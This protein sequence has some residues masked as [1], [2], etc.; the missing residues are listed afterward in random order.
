MVGNIFDSGAVKLLSYRSAV[1]RW[2]SGE[3]VVPI[4]LEVQPTERCNH[5]CPDCQARYALANAEVRRRAR[6]GVDLDL[7]VLRSVWESPPAGIVLSGNTGDPLLHPDIV[8]LLRQLARRAIPTV[9]I[10]NGEAM[11]PDIAEAAVRACR[12]IRL[13]LDAFDGDSFRRA[14]GA[15]TV[16][17]GRVL[18]GVRTLLEARRRTGGSRASCLIGVG[19][20]TDER[21]RAGMRA[22]AALARDLGVDY[23]QFRPYHHRAGDVSQELA[24]CRH[25]EDGDFQVFASNQKYGAG[26]ARRSYTRCHAAHAYHVLDARA[27]VYLCCHHVGNPEA[28][29]GSLRDQDWIS[30]L[31]AGRRHRVL[32]RFPGPGCVP[33]CRL[34]AHNEALEAVLASG[35]APS[36]ELAGDVAAHRMFL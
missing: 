19:Y 33:L 4:C 3:T 31:H 12:G 8:E 35:S 27:D 11:T 14:H 1:A 5:R 20:L 32:E 28:R 22:A 21:T 13:S 7:E 25:L 36:V 9:L 10:S 24:A 17:W 26:L 18:L 2:L 23:I 15:G 16:S 6:S 30:L 34:H 29:I